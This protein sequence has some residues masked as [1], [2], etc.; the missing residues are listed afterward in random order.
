MNKYRNKKPVV[1][2]ITFD[3]KVESEYYL[4][5][6]DDLANGR[7]K[8]FE[9]QPKFV[10]QKGFCTNEGKNIRPIHYVADF[11]ITG[12]SGLISI[13]D[14]KGLPTPASILKKKM[15]QYVYRDHNLLWLCYSKID[16]GWIEYDELKK[17]RKKR[18]KEKEIKL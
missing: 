10:L 3:S 13:V 6:K 2:G 8:S 16:G 11:S 18:K 17:A 7:I 15:F 1:D 14:I 9:L 5:L 12:L 4:K